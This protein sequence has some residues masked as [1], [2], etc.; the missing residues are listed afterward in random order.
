MVV[1]RKF[2]ASSFSIERSNYPQSLG[3]SLNGGSTLAAWPE[4]LQARLALT[5]KWLRHF[6]AG[7]NVGSKRAFISG[8]K[9]EKVEKTEEWGE[10]EKDWVEK[11]GEKKMAAVFSYDRA[12]GSR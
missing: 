11:V 9:T 4:L 6:S 10:N 12:R 8:E 5:R 7:S 1:F 2:V 3:T